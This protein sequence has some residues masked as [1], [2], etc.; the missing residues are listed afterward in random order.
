MVESVA[1]QISDVLEVTSCSYV[2][3]PVL[4]DRYAVLGHDGTVTR[5]GRVLAV[6]RHGLPTDEQTALLGIG[7]GRT[8]GYFLITAAAD[9]AYQ[10]LE[11]RR[12]A[13]LLAGQVAGGLSAGPV[14]ACSPWIQCW[15]RWP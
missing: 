1:R 10:S 5:G 11:Q 12:V 4:D 14:R 13:V 2:D 7:R 3:G 15:A 9:I 8:V 6:D